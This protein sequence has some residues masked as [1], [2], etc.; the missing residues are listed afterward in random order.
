MY[1]GW[2]YYQSN[3]YQEILGSIAMLGTDSSSWRCN[4]FWNVQV[5]EELE[6]FFEVEG[7]LGI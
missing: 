3:L 2:T 1:S 4:D 6:S 7:S 5:I